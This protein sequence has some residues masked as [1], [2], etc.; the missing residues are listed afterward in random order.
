MLAGSSHDKGRLLEANLSSR[1]VILKF[2]LSSVV[3][4]S[5]DKNSFGLDSMSRENLADE[6]HRSAQNI[7]HCQLPRVHFVARINHIYAQL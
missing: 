5:A 2:K 6:S 7:G 3:L 4:F 1:S